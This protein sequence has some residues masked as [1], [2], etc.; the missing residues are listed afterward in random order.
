MFLISEIGHGGSL[1]S[2]MKV[3]ENYCYC[4]NET[5]VGILVISLEGIDSC[6]YPHS[7][8]VNEIHK[9]TV[10][11]VTRKT[12]TAHNV[13]VDEINGILYVL[14]SVE[15]SNTDIPQEMD[16]NRGSSAL[17]YTDRKTTSA[18]HTETTNT[19]SHGPEVTTKHAHEHPTT[20]GYNYMFALNSN[21]IS[22]A[23]AEQPILINDSS[24]YFHDLVTNTYNNC[25]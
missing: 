23:S 13:Y 10:N 16:P 2:D 19:S 6:V 9:V 8:I 4:V 20:G 3:Y 15:S 7:A 5:A 17:N 12:C 1:W 21:I 14:G 18:A 25:H 22:G 11:G 24:I